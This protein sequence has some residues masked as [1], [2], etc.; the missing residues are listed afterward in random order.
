MLL[1]LEEELAALREAALIAVNDVNIGG[2]LL[3][4]HLWAM[5]ARIRMVALSGVHHGA[6]LALAMAQL[7]FGHDLHL[8]EP[9][10]PIGT[11]KE[12]KEELTGDFT[13]AAEAI[14][15]ATHTGD[16]VLAAFFEL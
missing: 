12:E 5:L 16:V 1:A 8:L 11:N 14:V 15:A 4:D 7:R 6:V 3:E 9:S 2:V 10:F 13:A